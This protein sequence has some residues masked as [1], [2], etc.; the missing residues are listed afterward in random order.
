MEHLCSGNI[1]YPISGAVKH[2]FP[3]F[4]F[5]YL[6]QLFKIHLCIDSLLLN[7]K[8]RLSQKYF[9]TNPDS[10]IKHQTVL[11]KHSISPLYKYQLLVVVE[12]SN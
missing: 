12:K 1:K 7:F 5:F 8:R 10:Q 6:L 9:L 4:F 3:M 11:F 2:T